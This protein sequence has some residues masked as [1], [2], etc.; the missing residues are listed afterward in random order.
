MATTVAQGN[1]I[2]TQ[3]VNRGTLTLEGDIEVLDA[4][5]NIIEYLTVI[6]QPNVMRIKSSYDKAIP[7]AGKTFN[8][9]FETSNPTTV[10]LTNATFSDGTTSKS[11]NKNAV[12]ANSYN[13][14]TYA[15]KVNA[16]SS[17]S[18]R[19]IKITIT[20]GLETE[21]KTLTQLG[22]QI[23]F[24]GCCAD[25]P[26]GSLGRDH[27]VY[28]IVSSVNSSW[29]HLET[30]PLSDR[31]FDIL[32]AL[33]VELN[34]SA[35][36]LDF[37]LI[38][39]VSMAMAGADNCFVNASFY[40]DSSDN[41]YVLLTGS[42]SDTSRTFMNIPAAGIY[43]SDRS[44]DYKKNGVHY[45]GYI[46]IA[47]A[48]SDN[49]IFWVDASGNLKMNIRKMG[50]DFFKINGVHSYY[51]MGYVAQP[52]PGETIIQEYNPAFSKPYNVSARFRTMLNSL[53]K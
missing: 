13:T 34:E 46:D 26:L 29:T 23:G 52:A 35:G 49:W 21:T 16:L 40:K 41:R 15:I 43:G 44:I 27:Y 17:S 12:K 5:G 24:R 50:K 14:T 7:N 30:V 37:A 8:V 36:I 42:D 28:R 10:K 22:Q 18:S 47:H 32:S 3:T 45:T 11:I 38:N 9:S 6:S 25:Y 53:G 20:N 51:P 39:G 1:F 48:T 2:F 33:S 4:S 19:Q 31:H